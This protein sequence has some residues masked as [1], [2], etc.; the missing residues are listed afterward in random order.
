VSSLL[1]GVLG[2]V[3]STNPVVAASNLVTTN[4]GIEVAVAR[5]N[6]VVDAEYRRLLE[7]DDRAQEQVDKWIRENQEFSSRGAGIPNSELNRKIT[8]RFEPIR[9]GYEDFIRR[10]PD[11]AQGRIAFASFLGDIGDEEGAQ[12]QLEKALAIDPKNPAI[13]NNLANIHGHSGST[14]KAFEYYA[15]AIELNPNEPTYYHNLGTTVY[16]FR[17]DA[18]EIYGI[19]EDEVFAKAFSL[20]SN[21][22]RLDPQNFPLASDVAQ[23]YYGITPL[24]TDDALRAW[25]NAYGIAHDDVE[26]EGV[27]LHFARIKL[28]SG[29]F[30][31]ARGHLNSVTN[32]MYAEMKQRLTRNLNEKEESARTNAAPAAP[33]S[34]GKESN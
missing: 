13:Y 20:Y 2:A 28:L 8:D 18:K 32:S 10:H 34:Q 11:H 15:K 9:T 7:D 6:E 14:K 5:T 16:L 23:T 30:E 24:R 29:R 22:M 19:N 3:L 21:A 12:T 26:K 31:E 27:Q 33:A 25:T 17:K 4:V 1:F